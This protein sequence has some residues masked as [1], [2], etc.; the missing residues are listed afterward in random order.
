MELIQSLIDST[1]LGVLYALVAMG[2]GLI[3][4]VMRLVNFAHGELI[5]VGAYTLFMTKAYP[6][7]VRV[8]AALAVVLLVALL[9]EFLYRPLRGATAATMLVA[10]FAVSFVLQ[11]AL[12][13]VFGPQGASID[14]LPALNRAVEIGELRIRW[15]TIIA[16]AVGGAILGAM[17]WLLGK[18]TVGLQIRAAAAD[19]R[20]AQILGVR[21]G[22]V[23]RLAFAIGGLL[24]GVVTLVLAVQRPLVTPTYGFLVLVPA[25]VGVVVGGLGRLLPA[26]LGGFVIGFATVALGDILP[27]GSRVFLNSLLFALVI[28]VLLVRPD[29]LFARRAGV[30][31][32]V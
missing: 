14:F 16:V 13:L 17:M 2:I 6:G 4:G 30:A 22:F 12:L 8:G 32:R 31:E 5:T 29:G 23:I 15:I 3:F 10:T 21:A 25:L 11:N 9:M 24:A 19:F 18:T 26:T 7:A 28:V 20:T 1:A 27:S